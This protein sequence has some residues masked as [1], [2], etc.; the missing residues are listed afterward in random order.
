MQ[1]EAQEGICFAMSLNVIDKKRTTGAFLHVLTNEV[2][3]PSSPSV[4]KSPSEERRMRCVG[5]VTDNRDPARLD[6]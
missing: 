6:A 1:K 2:A 3:Q 4:L 5:V